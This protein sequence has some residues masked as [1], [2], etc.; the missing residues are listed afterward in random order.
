MEKMQTLPNLS[1]I[2]SFVLKIFE[3]FEMQDFTFILIDTVSY[4]IKGYLFT[5][6]VF[7]GRRK[8]VTKE[9]A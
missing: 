7:C 2:S 8:W 9:N 5:I 4:V 6:R 3:K 1:K